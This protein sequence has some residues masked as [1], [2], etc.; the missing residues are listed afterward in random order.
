MHRT[1]QPFHGF[2][3]IRID[4]GISHSKFNPPAL[5][6]GIVRGNEKEIN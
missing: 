1:S 2:C 5:T 3:G 4:L 6:A